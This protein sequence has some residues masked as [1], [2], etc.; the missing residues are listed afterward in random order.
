MDFDNGQISIFDPK[1]KK[2]VFK[3]KEHDLADCSTTPSIRK[4]LK[5][6]LETAV[7]T[8]YKSE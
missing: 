1:G 7:R 3:L 2:V 5:S 6:D 8:H 4:K